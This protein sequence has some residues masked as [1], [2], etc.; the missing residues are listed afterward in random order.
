MRIVATFL[1]AT[2]ASGCATLPQT[3]YERKIEVRD[4]VA[5][6]EC[7]LAAVARDAGLTSFEVA[8]WGV[9]SSL[10]LT[11]VSTVGADGKVV[12]SI[13]FNVATLKLTPSLGWE[14]KNTSIAHLDFVTQIPEAM[15]HHRHTCVP[16]LDPSET[17]LGLASWFKTTL[18]AVGAKDHAGL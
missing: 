10:D 18:L 1:A 2:F 7:E 14:H 3:N 16:G 12:W 11:L 6:V 17:G 8:A 15:K 4:I 9:K 5:T 13:P